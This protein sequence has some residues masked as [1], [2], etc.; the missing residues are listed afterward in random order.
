MIVTAKT[1]QILFEGAGVQMWN[2]CACVICG[3]RAGY[4]FVDGRPPM[5]RG[6]HERCSEPLP[7]RPSSWQDVAD[8]LN[9]LP[10]D[11]LDGALRALAHAMEQNR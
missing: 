4:V 6:D 2:V 11:M 9:A 7:P 5:W 1:A 3:A 8:S 10:A